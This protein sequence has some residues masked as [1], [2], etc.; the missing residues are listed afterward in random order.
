MADCAEHVHKGGGPRPHG[1][2]CSG[3]VAVRERSRAANVGSAAE[4][5]HAFRWAGGT[6][7]GMAA[8]I[9]ASARRLDRRMTNAVHLAA[10]LDSVNVWMPG[11][12]GRAFG[13]SSRVVTSRG[14]Q[15][16]ISA[17]DS[18]GPA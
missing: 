10:R 5:A 18:T 11:R 4:T 7:S 2:D 16:L 12:P 15:K 3:A 1:R 9:R 14:V 8:G 13:R 6:G 17:V